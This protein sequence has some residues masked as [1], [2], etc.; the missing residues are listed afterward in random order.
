MRTLAVS[1]HFILLERDTMNST[2]ALCATAAA[3]TLLLGGCA[4]G[5]NSSIP[6]AS[7]AYAPSTTSGSAA[8]SATEAFS[9][10]AGTASAVTPI[11]I[12]NNVTSYF[13]SYPADEITGAATGLRNGLQTF[14]AG[15]GGTAIGTVTPFTSPP[16]GTGTTWAILAPPFGATNYQAY[17]PATVSGKQ[18]S[19]G[20]AILVVGWYQPASGDAKGAGFAYSSAT[21]AYVS[22]EPPARFCGAKGCN[23]TYMHSVYGT[24]RNYLTCGNSDYASAPPAPGIKGVLA[25]IDRVAGNAVLY[26]ASTKQWTNI[27]VDK[28]LSTTCYGIWRNNASVAL[29][30]GYEDAGR[31]VHG[32]VRDL[33]GKHFVQ[34][35]YPGAAITHFEGIYGLGTAGNYNLVGTGVGKSQT[36]FFLEIRDWKA[37]KPVAIPGMSAAT[38]VD[39]RT[40][41]GVVINAGG[42]AT[43]LTPLSTQI[44]GKD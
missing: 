17:G 6:S 2:S 25:E 44:A 28:A 26:D 14:S 7:S 18:Y 3:A 24:A 32:Y 20:D 38:S 37:L 42:A 11:V 43:A 27:N 41:S 23:D 36:S 1:H 35:D 16:Y 12:A 31:R 10:P 34:Y 4:G 40:V 39:D 9:A 8:H 5:S 33:S 29:T 13:S 22:L 19:P 15:P 21:N 30:G